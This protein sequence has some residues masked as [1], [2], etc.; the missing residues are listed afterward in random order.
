ME[1]ALAG[2]CDRRGLW[3]RINNRPAPGQ[4]SAGWIDA[5]ALG[6][7]GALFIELKSEHGR[8]TLAQIRLMR[9]LI[10]LGLDYRL[11]RP[12]DLADGGRADT[13]LD[14]IA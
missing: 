4:G 2:K 12:G 5:I 1:A 10:A 9:R 8:R 14:A 3:Y 6:W 13:D 7:T 11:Y